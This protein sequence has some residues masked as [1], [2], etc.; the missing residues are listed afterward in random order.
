[1]IIE[2]G[3][4][5]AANPNG[6]PRRDSGEG[7]RRGGWGKEELGWVGCRQ[8]ALLREAPGSWQGVS[9]DPGGLQEA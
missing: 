8:Q 7:R 4:C 3:E 5:Q 6:K 9:I 1:M 2:E